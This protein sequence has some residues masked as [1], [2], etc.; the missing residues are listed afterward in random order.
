MSN[1]DHDRMGDIMAG[2][3]KAELLA[4][5]ALPD[6]FSTV[7]ELSPMDAFK[8]F[9]DYAKTA[10]GRKFSLALYGAL[11]RDAYAANERLGKNGMGR[12][13]PSLTEH[14]ENANGRVMR[15]ELSA[16]F[17]PLLPAIREYTSQRPQDPAVFNRLAWLADQVEVV[18]IQDFPV[19]GLPRYGCTEWRALKKGISD[20][21]ANLPTAFGNPVELAPT[22]TT[23]TTDQ[24]IIWKGQPAELFALF[25]ELV[26]KGWIELPK[27]RGKRSRD[28][29]AR[30]V[31]AV[32]AFTSGTTLKV[33][34]AVNYLKKGR[35]GINEQ[36]PEPRVVFTLKRNPDVGTDY[37]PD[38]AGE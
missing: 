14:Q 22:A 7:Q 27:N 29:L 38:K 1:D 10:I 8:E 4:Q 30:T 32:F 2:P 9:M 15:H 23:G 36:R 20:T 11:R 3:T 35:D 19:M 34:T 16:R 18:N 28:K 21:I 6:L 31:H 37:D 33:G 5:F 12:V 13:F 26:G 25:E 17:A 24:P